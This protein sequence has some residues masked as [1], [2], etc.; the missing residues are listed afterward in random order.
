MLGKIEG[1]RRS[2][3][4]RMKWL[5]GISNSMDLSLSELQEILKDREVWRATVPGVEKSQTSDWTTITLPCR[6]L[7][8]HVG[9][10]SATLNTWHQGHSVI[11]ITVP[12]IEVG[13]LH[14]L[15]IS[16][17]SFA[18]TT[19]WYVLME[20]LSLMTTPTCKDWGMFDR[21]HSNL[22]QLSHFLLTPKPWAEGTFII[23]L[24]QLSL[25]LACLVYLCY[26]LE[27][28]NPYHWSLILSPVWTCSVKWLGHV[29]AVRIPS[30]EIR[31]R[32]ARLFVFF[33]DL[34]C[35][36]LETRDRK[37]ESFTLSLEKAFWN[38]T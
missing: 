9:N 6:N 1:R 32:R 33:V 26:L 10:C 21:T 17:G 5:D 31:G 25:H 24:L 15:E 16:W 37:I 14:G 34:F 7:G 8:I 11:F 29:G 23:V 18:C 2:G 12:T 13:K 27:I 19:K 28:C 3:G 36:S 20:E 30:A 38:C 22:F 35:G 4:Q